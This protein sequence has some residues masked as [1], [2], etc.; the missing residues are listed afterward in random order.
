MKKSVSN[1]LDEYIDSSTPENWGFKGLSE[2]DIERSRSTFQFYE[3]KVRQCFSSETSFVVVHTDRLTAFDCYIDLVP[4][5]GVL[6]NLISDYWFHQIEGKVPHHFIR[7][8]DERTLETRKTT[9]IKAEVV[10]R[11]YLAGSMLRKYENGERLFCGNELPSGLLP[12]GK[13]PSPIITPTTKAEVFEH[14]EP[15]SAKEIIDQNIATAEEWKKIEKM[16]FDLFAIG[17]EVFAKHG[18]ILADTKYEFGRTADGEIIVI[19]EIHTPDSSRLWE[20]ETYKEEFEAS[21]APK[22]LD[23]EIIR[24]YLI[25]EG[26]SGEG[27]VPKV[28]QKL[29]AELSKVYL[30]VAEKL[31][32]SRIEIP[33]NYEPSLD[34]I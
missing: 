29:K 6:L 1:L 14:D 21:S 32:G 16:A 27:Q 25:S 11:G 22:M 15:T 13:L 7:K 10:V 4:Y 26:F 33:E 5:K 9:P 31:T 30:S 34:W 2:S 17:T 28:P 18:W 8:V 12:Y 3:G 23:K 24:Q 19:D 20:K